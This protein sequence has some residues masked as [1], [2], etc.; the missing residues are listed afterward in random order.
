[1]MCCMRVVFQ[2][3]D[4]ICMPWRLSPWSDEHKDLE[5]ELVRKLR[6]RRLTDQRSNHRHGL[7]HLLYRLWSF[8]MPIRSPDKLLSGDKTRLVHNAASDR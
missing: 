3:A 2:A 6:Q 4:R 5:Q 1:M 7:D 8:V